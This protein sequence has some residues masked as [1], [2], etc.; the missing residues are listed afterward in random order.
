MGLV[1]GATTRGPAASELQQEHRVYATVLS[2][3]IMPNLLLEEGKFSAPVWGIVLA[4]H[5]FLASRI[6]SRL[7]R[8]VIWTQCGLKWTRRGHVWMLLPVWNS[9]WIQSQTQ[10]NS[11]RYQSRSTQYLVIPLWCFLSLALTWHC[12]KISGS[13]NGRMCYIFNINPHRHLLAA[14]ALSAIINCHIQN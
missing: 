7:N 11:T 10:G 13:P 1:G 2:F 4:L 14:W 3:R 6:I 12:V 9:A 8:H 5:L